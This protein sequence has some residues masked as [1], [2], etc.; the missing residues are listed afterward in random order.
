MKEGAKV[1]LHIDQSE[2]TPLLLDEPACPN[3]TIDN[4]VPFAAN[5]FAMELARM[6][7]I[8]IDCGR[9]YNPIIFFGPP[10]IG[11]TH[12][13]NAIANQKS[14]GRV[15]L[16]NLADWQTEHANAVNKGQS[17]DLHRWLSQA[18]LVLVDDVQL[19]EHSLE[20]QCQLK[21]LIDHMVLE[22]RLLVLASE[23]PPAQIV[24]NSKQLE[25]RLREGVV[26]SLQMGSE[27]EK[28]TLLLR[29][30]GEHNLSKDVLLRLCRRGNCSVREL[31]GIASRILAYQRLHSDPLVWELI[32]QEIIGQEPTVEIETTLADE[33]ASLDDN[34]DQAL[35]FKEMLQNAETAEEQALALQIALSARLRQLNEQSDGG[36]PTAKK[37][38]IA[39]ELLRQG[40]TE[41]AVRCIDS[42]NGL[43]VG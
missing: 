3:M 12:L 2:Y 37:L 7:V 8:E 34:C 29:H 19:V 5:A 15:A 25:S 31:K 20:M 43:V 23:R 6:A 22:N 42:I 21:I 18:E 39:L 14:F 26:A 4:L 24:C 30:V 10:G 28:Q 27:I 1:S 9:L 11:K 40:D 17:R 36:G 38:E 16:F 32:P 33:T 13:L 41:Q 35:Q